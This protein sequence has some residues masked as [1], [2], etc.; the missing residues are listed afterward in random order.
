[1]VNRALELLGKHN[2]MFTEKLELSTPV[3]HRDERFAEFT[4][5]ELRAWIAEKRAL[6]AQQQALQEPV[7]DAEYRELED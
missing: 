2:G 5:D 4:P 7:A 3:G 6:E 1:M